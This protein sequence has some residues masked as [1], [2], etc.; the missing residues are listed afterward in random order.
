MIAG[1]LQHA[2]GLTSNLL[3]AFLHASGSLSHYLR[4]IVSFASKRELTL[5]S[6]PHDVLEEVLSY[7]D[8]Q[9]LCCLR[10]VSM[11]PFL[12]PP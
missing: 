7:L 10:L 5:A 2:A 6:L 11:V 9:T 1:T 4:P 8:V 3:P 12:L